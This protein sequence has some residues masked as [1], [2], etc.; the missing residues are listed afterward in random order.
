MQLW[1]HFYQNGK[2]MLE[3]KNIHFDYQNNNSLIND[4]NLSFKPASLYSVVGPSGVGKSTLLALISGQL[5]PSSGEVKLDSVDLTH[6][7]INER[8]IAFMFQFE[9]LFPHLNVLDNLLFPLKT[10]K[11]KPLFKNKDIKKLALEKLKEVGLAGFE[12][13]FIDTLSGGQKQRV[14]LAR[15]LLMKPKILLLDEPFSA[16]DEN[17]KYELNQLLLN[18][19]RSENII[20]IKITHDISE[21]LTF[22]DEVI[23]LPKIAEY[24]HLNPKTLYTHK[25][26]KSVCQFFKLG[27]IQEDKYILSQNLSIKSG[28]TKHKVKIKTYKS[29]GN[30]HHY[31]LEFRHNLF[32]YITDES[33]DDFYNKEQ[34]HITLYSNKTDEVYFTS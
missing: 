6:K 32:N 34:E 1:F 8:P 16:L 30:L 4:M 31:M 26:S 27:L 10:K 7:G 11:F 3:L 9:S 23:L 24:I 19:V 28:D 12:N 17:L 5:K 25:Q 15:T 29:L 14:T 2:R 20:A 21:A 33:F 13:R 22:S 18:I